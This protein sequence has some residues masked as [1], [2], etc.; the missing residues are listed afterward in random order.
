MYIVKELL[1]INGFIFNWNKF[2]VSVSIT[3]G[4]GILLKFYH[5]GSVFSDRSHWYF[6]AT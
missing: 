2:Q 1:F 4:V 3:N 5:G 6:G